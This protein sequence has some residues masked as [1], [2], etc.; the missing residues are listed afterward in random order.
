[1]NDS[2]SPIDLSNAWTW[3]FTKVSSKDKLNTKLTNF[4]FYGCTTQSTR[5]W[6]VSNQTNQ[7]QLNYLLVTSKMVNIEN[8]QIRAQYTLRQIIIAKLTQERHP[9]S[10]IS[11]SLCTQNN[12]CCFNH[13]LRVSISAV[14]TCCVNMIFQWECWTIIIAVNSGHN[15]GRV[16]WFEKRNKK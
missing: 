14:R 15:L 2:I 5:W 11:C 7:Y 8:I 1:M 6:D 10:N 16:I 4:E 9:L 12:F 3:C 13:C